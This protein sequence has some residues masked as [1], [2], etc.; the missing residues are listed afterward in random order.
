MKLVIGILLFALIGSLTACD[1]GMSVRPV[2]QKKPI[3]G[4]QDLVI[5]VAPVNEFIGSTWYMAKANITNS[6]NSTITITK[7]ELA[8]ERNTYQARLGG[9]KSYPIELAPGETKLGCGFFE[10]HDPVHKT[11]KDPAELRI[12]YSIG[13]REEIARVTV[14]GGPLH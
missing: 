12:H 1:P 3:S 5:D 4:A 9:G 6:A 8:A 2:A 7:C 14:A 13:G 10:L 11:F